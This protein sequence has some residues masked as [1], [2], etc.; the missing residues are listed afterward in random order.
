MTVG[1]LALCALCAASGFGAGWAVARLHLARH[2]ALLNDAIRRGT[3]RT[4]S[5]TPDGRSAAR[6]ERGRYSEENGA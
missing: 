4:Y 1:V 2:S 5:T 3:A 6:Y